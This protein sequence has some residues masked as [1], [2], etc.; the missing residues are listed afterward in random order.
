MPDVKEATLELAV[1]TY[2]DE[3]QR[4]N[5]ETAKSQRFTLLLQSLFGVQP[6]FIENYLSGLEKY[7]RIK[8]KDRIIRGRADQLSGSLIIEFETDISDA[9][10]LAEANAQ[11]GRYIACVWS[12]ETPAHRGHYVC[13]ASDGIR[14]R[15]YSPSASTA[16]GQPIMPE[17]VELTL[18]EE[19][20]AAA[21]PPMDFYFFLD[22]YLLRQ[23][24]LHPTTQN[25]VKDFGP[26]SHAFCA[27]ASRLL[28]RW[29]ALRMHSDYAIVYEVWE[30][31]L[32]I[33]YGS[34][35]A[36]EALFIRHT[37]L[38][39]L[40]KLMVW[41]RLAG[42]EQRPSDADARAILDGAYFKD[43]LSL[44]NFLEE[45]FFSWPARSEAVTTGT[46]CARLLMSILANYNLREI[47][48]D[49]LKSLYEGLVDPQTRHDLG[50]YYTPDWLAQRMAKKLL[51]DE[52][53]AS[54][55][56]TACGSGSFIY[57]VIREKREKMGD[58]TATLNHIRTAVVG[59]D[60]HPLACIVAKAN[61]V[62]ALGDLLAKRR[63]RLAIPIYL[64]NS[65]RLPEREVQTELWRRVEC[66]RAE[67]DGRTVYIPEA[68]ISD[69]ANYDDAIE[70]AR[71]FAA[72]NVGKKI[73]VAEFRNYVE[74][75]YPRLTDDEAVLEAFF[76]VVEAIK[77][78]IESK[79]DT[80]WAFVLKNSYKPLFLR[81]RFDIAIGNPPWLAYRYVERSDYQAFL[82]SQITGGYGL[83]KGKGHL[84]THVELATLFLL[85]TA[86]LYLKE[87]GR[88]GFVL[89]KSIF[90]GD[91]HDALRRGLFSGVCLRFTEAW[92]LEAVAPLFNI[93]AAVL[94]ARKQPYPEREKAIPGEI[95][96]GELPIR[97]CGLSKADEHIKVENVTFHLCQR[98]K[99]SFWSSE[100]L[101]TLLESVYRK[102]F[103]QGASIVPRCFW[104]VDLRTGPFGYDHERPPLVSSKRAMEQ[105]KSAYKD[106]M[107][108]GRMEQR[109]LYTT[110][111]SND[112][113]PFGYRCLSLTVL[114]IL[115]KGDGYELLTAE[116]ARKSG[117][118]LLYGWLERV[119]SEWEKRRRGKAGA[120]TAIEWL[121][122]RAKLVKQSSADVYRVLYGTSG[123]NLCA[124]V[125]EDGKAS[126]RASS[127]LTRKFV[128]DTKTYVLESENPDECSY[129]AAI[130]NA[131]V[132]DLMIKP[133]QS[134][135][136]W[137]A[138]DIHK[139]VLDLPIP[140]F[141]PKNRNHARLAEIGRVCA[142]RVEKWLRTDEAE[143]I[144]GIGHLRGKVRE[145]LAAE[146]AEIDGIAKPALGL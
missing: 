126:R 87:D 69:T 36:D 19:V 109:F 11:L 132:V 39:T 48:E 127:G 27:V 120:S 139:K 141:D 131:P 22:R 80:I 31:Y 97:N 45:D 64:A 134:R 34:S 140:L 46:E 110:L 72:L 6:G 144:R 111:L 9:R 89:P 25:V 57:A 18:L 24:K 90:S 142:E 122:Y 105:A 95:L 106:C 32:R 83:L 100:K 96:E 21:I 2:R 129:V 37:Y 101:G 70:A 40:A 92:D 61:Y 23:E 143:R 76:N 49:V 124:C 17:N 102:R 113:V 4:L 3:V 29:N 79:R 1:S 115:P 62:L 14:F 67:I 26:S 138:R 16:G 10:K 66:Y 94:F 107:I 104:F 63:G 65:I 119:Q 58:S 99:R 54:V 125:F 43:R 114:P 108:E 91:Q 56:D 50:E 47:S 133:A 7:V 20:N 84:V 145:L 85:R 112:M 42:T 68:L 121:D 33:V 59:I 118:V 53:R 135:G 74:T 81:R 117:C 73:T 128:A 77:S 12:A 15:A 44:E 78:M 82:K 60:I 137:G 41:L 5:S 86:D 88:I 38:A 71:D 136:L 93:S 103:A 28:E 35:V 51:A 123:T 52:P 13:L 75:H 8:E 98:G 30:K 146:L 55:I 130:L 116:Q